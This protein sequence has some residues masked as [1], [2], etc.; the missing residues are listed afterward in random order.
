MPAVVGTP[1]REGDMLPDAVVVDSEGARAPLSSHAQGGM[2]LVFAYRGSR[3][4]FCLQRLAD[5]RDRV[6]QFEKIGIKIVALSPD[7]P[8]VS[9]RVRHGAELPFPVLCDPERELMSTW[10]LLNARDM[11]TGMPATL[12]VDA[13]LR[14][15]FTSLDDGYAAA[16]VDDVL[17]HCQSLMRGQRPCAPKRVFRVPAIR[18]WIRGA[19]D[20]WRAATARRSQ[21]R[22]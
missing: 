16:S 8:E 18:W 5:Y 2:L 7:G 10:R 19:R 21:K 3:C 22:S 4:A 6:A 9:A 14:V 12:L 11:R 15:R 20:Y 13:A 1:P 17:A